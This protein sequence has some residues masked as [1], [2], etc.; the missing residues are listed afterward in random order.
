[1]SPPPPADGLIGECWNPETERRDLTCRVAAELLT[2][3]AR[4]GQATIQS[5]VYVPQALQ[6]PDSVYLSVEATWFFYRGLY[7]LHPEP[8]RRLHRA[9]PSPVFFVEVRPTGGRVF[10]WGWENRDELSI[11]ARPRNQ[12]PERFLRRI[13]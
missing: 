6:A 8:S 9:V 3:M 2:V 4:R 13:R 7:A 12:G 11:F 1:M 10:A 5:A